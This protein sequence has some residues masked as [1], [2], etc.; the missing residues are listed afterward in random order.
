MEE[1]ETGRR[2]GKGG[3]TSRGVM[4]PQRREEDVERRKSGKEGRTKRGK[5]RRAILCH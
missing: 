1:G 5:E 2:R 3:G 4:G